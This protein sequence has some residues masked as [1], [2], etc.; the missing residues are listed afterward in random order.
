MKNSSQIVHRIFISLLLFF[1][2]KFLIICYIVYKIQAG[3][4]STVQALDLI[5]AMKD[6]DNYTVWSNISTCMEKIHNLLI[7]ANYINLFDAYGLEVI[8][9][10][11]NKLG[12]EKRP[13]E[14]KFVHVLCLP[15]IHSFI[16]MVIYVYMYIKNRHAYF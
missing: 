15:E 13:D 9:P 11:Y 6:E 16:I 7:N 3:H 1:H 2:I 8:K 5:Y 4:E 10:I 12:Y 14:C